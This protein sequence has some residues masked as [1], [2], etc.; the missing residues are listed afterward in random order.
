MVKEL[1]FTQPTPES[2]SSKLR[3]LRKSRG[4]SLQDIEALSHGKLKAVVLGSYERGDRALSLKRAIEIATFYGIPVGQLLQTQSPQKGAINSQV[5]ID[6]R[7]LTKIAG[8]SEDKGAK[9]EAL[10][11]FV[12][13]IAE[14]RSDWNGEV[15]SLRS[16]DFETLS[17]MAR[18]P[19]SEL[20]DWLNQEK[21]LLSS[22]S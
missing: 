6:L 14:A 17:L 21:L 16:V 1:L 22:F 13:A 12:R 4:W 5:V 20:L 11:H 10:L 15:M 9:F 19:Q 18:C 3:Q 8:S 7:R 2:V